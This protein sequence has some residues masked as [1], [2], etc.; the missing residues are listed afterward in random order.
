MTNFSATKRFHLWMPNIFG[1][2]GGVQVYS[3]Y[4]LKALQNLCPTSQYDVFLK[5]DVATGPNL[6]YLPQTRF[7][8]AGRVPLKLRTPAFAAQLVG[9]GLLQRPDL[10]ITTHLNFTVAAHYLKRLTGIPYWAIAHGVEAWDIR[11]PALQAA[12][13]GADRI[14]CVSAY[15]RD[16]L[17]KEQALSPAQLALLPNTFDESRFQIGLKPVHLLQQYNLRPDQPVLLTVNRLAATE[18]YKGY[19]KVLEALPQVLKHFPDIHYLIVGKGDDQPRLQQRIRQM[20]LQNQVTLTGFI[21]DQELCDYYNLCDVFVMPSKLE[22]FGIVYLEALACGK[23][24]IGGNQDG[25][26]DALCQGKLGALVNPDGIGDIA[27]TITQILEKAYPNPLM[28]Q[29]EDLR[30]AVIAQYGFQPFQQKLEKSIQGFCSSS[31]WK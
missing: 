21:P 11:K 12:L 26:V 7:H 17:L 29:P 2:K 30:V 22:G 1:F 16:R 27:R 20:G 5:H 10:I 6:T 25:A 3:A 13:R 4:F 28:Y 8:F 31:Q 9:Q 23:P 19:D 14:L 24:A 15:T 18:S